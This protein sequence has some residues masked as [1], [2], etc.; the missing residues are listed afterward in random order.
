MSVSQRYE[1]RVQK[2]SFFARH[3]FK[4]ELYHYIYIVIFGKYLSELYWIVL[5]CFRIL[6]ALL[7]RMTSIIKSWTDQLLPLLALHTSRPGK[8]A[9]ELWELSID[10]ETALYRCY[11]RN[12]CSRNFG[13]FSRKHPWQGP[14]LMKLQDWNCTQ[15][16]LVR[17][18]F[19]GSFPK[20]VE[21]SFPYL[22]TDASVI[23]LY[24]HRDLH[25]F[26]IHFHLNY[27]KSYGCSQVYMI[28]GLYHIILLLLLCFTCRFDIM[29]TDATSYSQP[30][31]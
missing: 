11:I 19:P 2:F 17:G 7:A 29:Q 5:M 26:P 3:H 20:Y 27:S 8:R 30:D 23:S 1:E 9:Q 25:I 16:R 31:Y 13:N 10:S 15:L 14:V 22:W 24:L 4:A 21:Q 12:I 6:N 18:C 28:I